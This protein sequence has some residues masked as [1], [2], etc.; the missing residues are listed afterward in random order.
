M[1][2]VDRDCPVTE[3]NLSLGS[4]EKFQP[5]FRDEKRSER[6][7]ARNSWNKVTRAK[8]KVIT[9]A[10]IVALAA[11]IAVSLRL[12]GMLMMWK[13][14]WAKQHDAIWAVEFLPFHPGNRG[15]VFIWQNF[16]ARLTR[17]RFE[18]PRPR[19]PS[20]PAFS[21]ELIKHF[22]KDLKA[23]RNLW[24]RASPGQ[25]GSCEERKEMK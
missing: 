14:Q 22:T 2:P 9:F 12:N 6:V 23:R 1:S 7:L 3:T 20:Q 11:L 15:E 16:L 10:P 8:H 21:Y 5:G 25:P 24:N 17:S 4:Y 18:K 19:G 13:I